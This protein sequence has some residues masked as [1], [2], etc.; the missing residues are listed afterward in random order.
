MCR[1]G[2]VLRKI[3]DKKRIVTVLAGVVVILSVFSGFTRPDSDDLVGYLLERRTVVLQKALFDEVSLEYAETELKE[4]ETGTLLFEDIKSIQSFEDT[5]T[6]LV[7]NMKI[8]DIKTQGSFM[9]FDTY[10]VKLLW[11]LQERGLNSFVEEDYY[12]VL[13]KIGETYKISSFEPI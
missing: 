12:V 6:E 5:D 3:K 8:I 11:E 10:E 7:R 4:I 1:G 2:I 9:E 13:K